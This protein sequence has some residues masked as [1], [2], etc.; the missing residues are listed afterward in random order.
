MWSELISKVDEM[1]GA[2]LLALLGASGMY[3]GIDGVVEM[4][5]PGIVALLT[6]K[7]VKAK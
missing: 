1:Y 3:L 4:C 5:V 7:A 2:G 6:V